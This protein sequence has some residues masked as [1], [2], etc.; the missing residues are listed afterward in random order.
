MPD[1]ANE[2]DS[3]NWGIT[4]KTELVGTPGLPKAHS[5]KHS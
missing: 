4:V 5:H 2:A 1:I 3:G